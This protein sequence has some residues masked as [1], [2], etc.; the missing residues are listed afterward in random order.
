MLNDYNQVYEEL[1]EMNYN[2]VKTSL[3]HGYVSRKKYYG[4]A[5]KV[6]KYSGRYG[7]GYKVLRPCWKSTQYCYCEY[8]IKT[9]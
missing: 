6:E 4:N 5:C 8:W 9:N 2:R 7:S 3:T 1:R